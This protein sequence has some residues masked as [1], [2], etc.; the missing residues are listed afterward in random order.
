MP[1]AASSTFRRQHVGAR[2]IRISW[3]A[4]VFPAL[5]LNYLGQGAYL[6]SGAPVAGGKL[7]YSL[8]PAPLLL[9]LVV[10]ATLATIVASQALI[11]GAFSLTWQAIGLGLFPRLDVLHTH[12]AHAG[13][14]Y[15]PLIN[16]GLYLGCVALV[17]AFG[18]PRRWPPHTASRWRV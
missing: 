10:L 2:P 3:F 9:P 6:L 18:S 7:F 1:R 14:I 17:L 12:R 8:A 4:V 15:I 5:L 13:Q 11:S 16:W